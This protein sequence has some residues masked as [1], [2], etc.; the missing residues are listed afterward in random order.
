MNR[1]VPGLAFAAA[2]ACF[3]AS[4]EPSGFPVPELQK[5][6]V[7]AG[8][9]VYHGKSLDTEFSDTGTWTWDEHCQW[10][11]NRLF[12][13][14]TFDNDWSGKS[15]RSLVVNT[16]NT[17]DEQYWHYE[18]FAEGGS[19]KDPFVSRMDIDGN[20]WTEYG[21]SEEDGKT[22]NYRIV[23]EYTSPTRV[24]VEIK[25]SSNGEDWTTV[26]RGVGEKQE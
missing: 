7:S 22:V 25:A 11:G 4:A 1:L 2:I 13:Q 17:Q 24:T 19:G 10:S 20:T 9:W 18:F 3:A 26:D 8:H 6:D 12:L 23:Y 5:L 21:S 15:V 14:C 16:Y